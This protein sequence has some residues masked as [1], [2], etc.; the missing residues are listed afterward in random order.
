MV[1]RACS[2]AFIGLFLFI[3]EARSQVS[4]VD[5]F[6]IVINAICLIRTVGGDVSM[7][8]STSTP[9]SAISAATNSNTYLQITSIIPTNTTRHI[10]ASINA[11]TP[12]PAGT[13]LKL[14]ATGCTTGSGTFGTGHEVTLTSS[15]QEIVSG[16][17][18]CYTGTLSNNGYRLTYTWTPLTSSYSLIKAT[19]SSASVVARFTIAQSN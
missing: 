1:K 3:G 5:Q 2:V 14:K 10:T 19:T 18:S 16:I 11:T 7:N 4:V 13:T 12:L 9:G 17:G 8:L 6:N 15:D